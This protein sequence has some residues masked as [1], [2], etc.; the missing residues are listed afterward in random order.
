MD[1]Y[2][3]DILWEI[4]FFE[5]NGGIASGVLFI[6]NDYDGCLY[7]FGKGETATTV[8]VSQNPIAKGESTVIQ[9]TVTDQSAGAMGTPAIADEDMSEWMQHLYMNKPEP[10]D[11][12]GVTVSIC[13]IA[14]D[15][16]VIDIGQATS[17]SSGVYGLLWAPPDQDTYRIVASFDGSGSYYSSWA[18]TILG[19]TAAS[20]SPEFPDV[21]TAAEIA[22]ATINRLPPY[23][24]M[25]TVP[26]AAE[27]AQET[28]NRLPPYPTMPDVPT[29]AEVA[30]ETETVLEIPETP[31]F[32]TIDLVILV[33][34][35]I[36]VV[37]GLLAYMTLRKQ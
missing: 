24:T 15:G 22:Q 34:A 25:P 1:A 17:D 33:V 10:G 37:I 29:A 27:V 36:G 4:P 11:V 8:S 6:G 14:S 31:A 21:P 28:I 26:T 30:Q 16:T 5:G 18:E 13:A 35:A 23:P 20:V 7:A 32:L 2:T 3:G 19:V 12:N 9:G